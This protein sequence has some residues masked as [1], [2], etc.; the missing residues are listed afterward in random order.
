MKETQL[1]KIIRE[2]LIKELDYKSVKVP[3]EETDALKLI[4]FKQKPKRGDY[5]KTKYG[6]YYCTA[7]WNHTVKDK[8]YSFVK[9]EDETGE[10][11]MGDDVV[12]EI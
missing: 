10:P 9:T 2:E 12:I 3:K 11:L 7:L 4:A 1:R 5:I 6:T 8:F